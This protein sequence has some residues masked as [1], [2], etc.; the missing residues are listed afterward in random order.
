MSRRG[1]YAGNRGQ[2]SKWISKKK[3]AAI[4]ARDAGCVWCGNKFDLTI[5]HLIPRSRG[6]SNCASN[7]VTSCMPCN[8]NRADKPLAEWVYD[9]RVGFADEILFRLAAAIDGAPD[10][11]GFGKTRRTTN[12]RSPRRANS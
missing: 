3:R 9:L 7:L 1:K 4:Y 11:V 6:G 10:I 2:G 8:R 5:D 12:V